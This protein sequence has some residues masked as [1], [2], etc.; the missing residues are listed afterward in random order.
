MTLGIAAAVASGL[1]RKK[2][3][4]EVENLQS[5][6]AFAHERLDELERIALA[7]PEAL[8]FP[9]YE[10]LFTPGLYARTIKLPQVHGGYIHTTKIHASEHVWACRRG[11]IWVSGPDGVRLVE[12]GEMGVTKPGTRRILWNVVECHWT[13]FHPLSSE[14]EAMR[15]AGASTEELIAAIERRIIEWRELDNGM[16]AFEMFT[17]NPEIRA[18]AQAAGLPVANLRALPEEGA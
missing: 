9:D 1:Y 6:V 10:H 17:S 18:A 11:S 13:C 5:A 7:Q 3:S 14:E 2:P 15:Q 16:S 12:A 4:P 8:L